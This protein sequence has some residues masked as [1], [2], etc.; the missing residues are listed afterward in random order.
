MQYVTLVYRTSKTLQGTWDGR[1]Y[2]ITPGKHAFPEIQALKFR[3]QNPLMGSENPFTLEKQYLIGIE[4]KGDDCSSLEQSN[5]IEL[6]DR[7]PLGNA[8]KVMVIKGHGI[9][10][11]KSDGGKPFSPN[12]GFV[13]ADK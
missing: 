4:E 5:K 13:P 2:D 7:E 1:H 8:D 10:S 9:Y 6:L 11:P 12:T 3:E